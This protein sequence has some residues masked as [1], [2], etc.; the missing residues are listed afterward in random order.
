MTGF[1][2]AR[3]LAGRADEQAGEQV[4]QRRMALP[5][6]HQA[7]QQI[8]A[9]QERAVGGVGAADHDMVAAAGAGVAAVD[10][11]LVGAEARLARLLVDR[12]GDVDAF[13]PAGGRMD[14]DLDDAGIGRDVDDVDALVMRR[15]IAFD[16]DRQAE[17]GCGVFG[18]GDQ[19]E[20][21]LD[22]LDRRHEHAEAAVARLDRHG[23]AHGAADFADRSARRGSGRA[24]VGLERG[25]RHGAAGGHDDIGQ[26]LAR[27]RG[28]GLVDIGIAA[29]AA[30]RAACRAAGGSRRGNRRAP[31]RSCRG[32]CCHFSLIQRWPLGLARSRPGPAGYSRSATVRP[33]SNTRAMRSR[34][35]GSF[36]LELDGS[37]FSGRLPS[38]MIHSAGSSIGGQDHVGLDRRVPL[39]MPVR[40]LPASSALTPVS[41]PSAAIRS[42]FCQIGLPSLRQ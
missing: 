18:R 22:P 20:I 35:S 5:V 9:A 12:R 16:M 28:I 41:L 31:G 3:R 25:F 11:E 7:F 23:G 8:R 32:G 34:S 10:H 14:V 37:T 42:G 24:F 40:S 2:D 4:G 26:R 15:R 17:F 33:R 6:Q 13:L 39:A 30:H 27:D 29:T 36:S 21:V 19:L 38:L 1:V